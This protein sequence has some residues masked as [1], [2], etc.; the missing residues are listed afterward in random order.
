MA[1]SEANTELRC[2]KCKKPTQLL[3][4]R[5]VFG[6]CCHRKLGHHADGSPQHLPKPESR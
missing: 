4:R 2:P 1:Q 5:E 3:S 6:S